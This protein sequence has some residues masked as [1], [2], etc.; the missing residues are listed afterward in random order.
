MLAER[1]AEVAVDHTAGKIG[2]IRGDGVARVDRALAIVEAEGTAAELVVFGG[3]GVLIDADFANRF[4]G[5]KL[6]AAEA[7]DVN[8]AAIGSGA[9]SGERLQGVGEIVGIVGEGGEVFAAQHQCGGV[10]VGLHAECGGGLVSDGDLLLRRSHNHLDGHYD[11]T[12][13]GDVHRLID[14]REAGE[15]D[16][17]AVLSGGQALKNVA[18]VYLGLR[19][20]V[21]ALSGK[22]DVGRG[23]DPARIVSHGTAQGTGSG[24]GHRA[25]NDQGGRQRERT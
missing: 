23:D 20:A 1:A 16:D 2:L 14:R 7:I 10:I 11:I 3:E 19:G 18:S 15:T 8:G 9:G 25:R 12:S 17:D 24:L 5:R 13:G 21:N 22:R 4:L 6:A